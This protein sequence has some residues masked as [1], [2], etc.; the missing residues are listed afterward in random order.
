MSES[1]YAIGWIH[2]PQCSA[3]FTRSL[4][5]TLVHDTAHGQRI[6][7]IIDEHSSANVSTARNNVVRQFLRDHEDA[8]WLLLVDADMVWEPDAPARLLAAADADEMPILGALCHG[9]DG[10]EELFSTIFVIADGPGGATSMR[11]VTDYPDAGIG[12]CSATGAAFLLVHRTVLAKMEA[13]RFDEAFPWFQE[14]SIGAAPVSEDITFCLR[15]ERLG[16]PVHV[17][18]EVEVGHHKS[19]VLTKAKLRAQQRLA[20]ADA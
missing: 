12:K 2:G 9:V 20:V 17:H 4:Y 11:R 19:T 13:E 10:N 5:S 3:L 14:T 6:A 18:T 7:G 8:D 15:A 1:R 16:F